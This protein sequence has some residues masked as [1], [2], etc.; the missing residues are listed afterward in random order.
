MNLRLLNIQTLTG[1][2]ANDFDTRL[3]LPKKTMRPKC[4][5]IPI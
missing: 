3:L 4:L 5:I 2:A 1:F